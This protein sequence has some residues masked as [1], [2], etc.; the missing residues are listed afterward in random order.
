MAPSHLHKFGGSSLADA[1]CYRRVAHILLTHGRSD[2][3]IVVSAAGKT[4]NF[5]YHILSL[6]KDGEFWRESL[7]ELFVY[8]Q[9]L[10]EQLL[11]SGAA[12]DLRECLSTDKAQICSLLS[13]EWLNAYQINKLISFG[14]R[15]S[16]R[17]MAALLRDYGVAASHVDAANLLIADEGIVPQIRQSE[18]KQ[19]ID[20]WLKQH[21]FERIVITGFNCADPN[22]KMLLLGRNGSDYSATLFASLAGIERVTIW[23][24]VEGVYNADPNKFIDAN[25]LASMTLA[26]ANRLAH[27]GSPILHSRTLEPLF[28][29]NISLA[30][31]SSYVSH[32]NFTLITPKSHCASAPVV[33][34]LE[35]IALFTLQS[36]ESTQSLLMALMDDK[37]TP[38]AFWEHNKDYLELA[39]PCELQ[40]KVQ[41]KLESLLSKYQCGNIRINLGYGLV[42]LICSNIQHYRRSFTRLLNRYAYPVYQ[43]EL[44]L[45]TLVPSKNVNLLTQKIHRRCAGAKKR[46]GVI[47]FGLGSI[48]KTWIKLFKRAVHGLN[49]ELETSVEL[50]GIVDLEWAYI[51]NDGIDLD[52][53]QTDFNA[54]GQSWNYDALF[55]S[56]NSVECDEIIIL[57]ISDSKALSQ[58]YSEFFSRGIHIVSANKLA[59]SAPLHFYQE[60]KSL[61][62]SK[63]IYWRYNASY[64]A[65]LPV[66]HALTDLQHNGDTVT[67][68]SGIFSGALCWLFERYNGLIPFSELVLEAKSLGICQSDPR[69][70]LCGLDMQ[71][72]LL[73]LAREIGFDL[74]LEDVKVLSPI[75]HNLLHVPLAEFFERITEIDAIME[76]EYHLAIRNHQLL[77]FI[78]SLEMK[79]GTVSAQG[80]LRCVNQDSAYANLTPGDNVFVIH[81]ELHQDHPLIIRGPG[82]SKE[83]TAA[84]IQSDLAYICRDLI[85]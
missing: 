2:D 65:G 19:R 53:W 38:L 32:S 78:A 25:L 33:T 48:G 51:S 1:D 29:T 5:L 70:D 82:A 43:D 66:Q 24:D 49:A 81:S 71:R 77:R 40:E 67:C 59:G 57:D 47:L 80:Q 26:E 20:K 63:C 21:P 6:C 52:D 41:H 8:Q 56:I 42:A 60:L 73:I 7:Q 85:D 46:I 64:G 4:T 22:G 39:F 37:L 31:R 76:Q 58:R 35:K 54:N 16:A 84:A 18:S 79:N 72:K 3:V 50:V 28:G 27:L 23:T 17:L 10:I 68:I 30:V 13:L 61:L 34:N 74:E 11:S 14:E 83:V 36:P 12:R 69:I 44:S 75:P 55:P 45:V 62:S 9:E 15:W